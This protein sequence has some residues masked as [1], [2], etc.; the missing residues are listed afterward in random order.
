MTFLPIVDRELRMAARRRATYWTRFGAALIAIFLSFCILMWTKDVSPAAVGRGLFS[1]LSVMAFILCLAAGLG[2]TADCLSEEKREGTLGLLFLTDLKGYDVVLGKLAANSLNSIYAM[3]AIFP[4]LALPLLLG[5][6]DPQAFWRMVLHLINTLFFSL[7]AG[8]F[9]SAVSR[10]SRRAV[11]GT[12]FLIL[13]IAGGLPLIGK[14][15]AEFVGQGATWP[16]RL[17]FLLPSPGYAQNLAFQS[18]FGNRLGQYFWES[19]LTVHLLGWVFLALATFILPRSWQD[20]PASSGALRWRDRWRRWAYGRPTARK[21]FRTRLLDINPFLW[22]A[23]RYR[24]KR[25]FVWIFLGLVAIRW[26]AGYLRIQ[27]EWLHASVG[28]WTTLLMHFVLKLWITSEACRTF[29]EH[30]RS[31]VLELLLSTPVS[32]AEILHGQILAL[33]QQFG[34]PLI[35]ALVADFLLLALGVKQEPGDF[36]NQEEIVLVFLICMGVLVMDAYALSWVGMWCGLSARKFNRAASATIARI[37]LLPWVIFL[38]SVILY[39]AFQMYKVYEPKSSEPVLFWW[40]AI[41][42]GNNLIF[43]GWAKRRLHRDFRQIAAEHAPAAAKGGWWPFK[44]D[45]APALPPP[46]AVR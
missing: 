46:L 41:A 40:L 27:Q 4:V 21:A 30:R 38:G 31:G 24:A 18:A 10:D 9:I 1:T 19:L 33:R 43:M 15:M 35:V 36:S 13:M 17:Y 5:G 42:L 6:V 23:G 45:K 2:N 11:V 29:L 32:V 39:A 44:R 28:I 26:L 20:R 7:G 16:Y 8:V 34:A 14:L 37:L 12:F 25:V 22:L 3:L